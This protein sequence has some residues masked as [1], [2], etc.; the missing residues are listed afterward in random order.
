MKAHGVA[1]CRG[2]LLLNS[3]IGAWTSNTRT[4]GSAAGFSMSPDLRLRFAND[5]CERP[6]S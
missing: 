6:G 4:R 3:I 1:R 5:F 2:A